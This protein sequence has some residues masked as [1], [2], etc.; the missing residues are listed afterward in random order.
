MKEKGREA[1]ERNWRPRESNIEVGDTV[2]VK[3]AVKR[4]KFDSNFNPTACTV[5]ASNTD[6]F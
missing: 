2:L 4:S 1:A 5:V 6:S 3:R